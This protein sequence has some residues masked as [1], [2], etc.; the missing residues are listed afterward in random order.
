MKKIL[1]ISLCAVLALAFTFVACSKDNSA[2][3]AN[4]STDSNGNSATAETSADGLN[5]ADNEYGF[6]EEDVTDKDGK[7]VTDKNG[8]TVTTEVAVA[9]HTDAKGNTYAQRIDD[10]GNEVTKKNGKPVTVKTQTTTK[11]SKSDNKSTGKADSSSAS[12]DTTKANS[13]SATRATT[14]TEATTTAKPTATTKKDAEPTKTSDTTKFDGTEK[15]PKT[16]ATG[17][18]VNFSTSDM[19]TV[20]S[21]LEVPYLYL[22]SYENS[23]GV[24][25]EIAAYTAVWMAQHDGG[26]G[27]TYPSSPVVLN[28]FKYYG[29]TVVNF[30]TKV[31]DVKDS[32]IKYNSK[33]D[34]FTVSKYPDKKQDIKITKIE[35]LGDN[36]FYKVTADVTGAGK[37]KTVQAIIQKNK[38]DSTL[39]FSI[40]ALNWK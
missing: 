32:P 39:D 19:E 13:P 18:E 4:A 16:S 34:T 5:S 35:D 40:K 37:I 29:Q 17:K 33:N 36:N 10:N 14:T 28:L 31:N 20:A 15:V 8:K 22:Q 38:L 26:T 23:D 21:M 2:S 9:Y 7:K 25:I 3:D 11:A 6:E 1:I 27:E 12:S 30:K 24:P